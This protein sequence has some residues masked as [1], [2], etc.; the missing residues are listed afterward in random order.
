[1]ERHNDKASRAAALLVTLALAGAAGCPEAEQV[2]RQVVQPPEVKVSRVR[3]TGVSRQTL[4]LSLGVEIN[5]PNPVGVTLAGIDYRFELMGRPLA[6]GSAPSGIELAAVGASEAE[7]PVSLAY[8]EIKQVYD[9]AGDRDEI[10]YAV[11]GTV[12]VGT[13]IGEIPIPFKTEGMLPVI[14]APEVTGISMEVDKLSL[15]GADLVLNINLKNPNAFPL[16]IQRF[17]YSLAL[18]GNEFTSGNTGPQ[19]VRAKH[20]GTMSIP[21]HIDF[22]SAGSWAYSLITGGKADYSMNY[23]AAFMIKGHPVV[24]KERKEGSLDLY[25]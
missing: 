24:Q 5:N 22:A 15:S 4:D 9:E 6:S 2:I 17:S 10:P 3:V 11:S 16:D 25:R 23:E 1:M 12:S 20:T 8:N 14:R 18:D 19:T 21:V 7:F 13:P